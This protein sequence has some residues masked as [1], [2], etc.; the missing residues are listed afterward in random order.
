MVFGF[1]GEVIRLGTLATHMLEQSGRDRP[2]D[3]MICIRIFLSQ[4]INVSDVFGFVPL[5]EIRDAL[6]GKYKALGAAA[7]FGHFVNPGRYR[8]HGYSTCG[9]EEDDQEWSGYE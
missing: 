3:F 9:E 6:S 5:D 2:S 7:E 8:K 1:R 4:H